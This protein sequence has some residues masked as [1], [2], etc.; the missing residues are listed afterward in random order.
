MT[1]SP[2]EEEGRPVRNAPGGERGGNPETPLPRSAPAEL[3]LSLK[4]RG[5]KPA[6]LFLP[7][8]SAAKQRV[9]EGAGG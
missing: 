3:A 4:G 2:L 6:S 7:L 5:G 8:S 1:P 9:G